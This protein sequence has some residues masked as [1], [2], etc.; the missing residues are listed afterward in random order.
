M[1][2]EL[3]ATYD[4][5]GTE[6]TGLTVECVWNV[7]KAVADWLSAT[8]PVA[9]V[10]IDDKTELA[11]AAIE[12]LRLQGRDVIDAGRGDKTVAVNVIATKNLAGAIVIGYDSI[13]RMTTIELY[14]D[15]AKLIDSSSGLEEIRQLV[16]AGNFV[17]AVL[18]GVLLPV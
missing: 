5:R 14:Q 4:I 11:K 13:E 10:Y 17:P 7:G 9:I 12:G 6:A 16:E 1:G 15:Q 18:R 8:G 3:I 2:E